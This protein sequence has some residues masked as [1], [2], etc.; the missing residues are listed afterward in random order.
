MRAMRYAATRD[1]IDETGCAPRGGSKIGRAERRQQVGSSVPTEQTP[2][3][4]VGS[5]AT[6][7]RDA[8]GGRERP[9]A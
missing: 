6:R 1:F 2:R 7:V 5:A 9:D 8:P 3:L 4:S